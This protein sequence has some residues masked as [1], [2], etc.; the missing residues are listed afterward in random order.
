[1]PPV[2]DTALDSRSGSEKTLATFIFSKSEAPLRLDE[3]VKFPIMLVF[4]AMHLFVAASA[5]LI[6]QPR[7]V[8]GLGGRMHHTPHGPEA[9]VW[10]EANEQD[11]I[12]MEVAENGLAGRSDDAPICVKVDKTFETSESY[13]FYWFDVVVPKDSAFTCSA[14]SLDEGYLALNMYTESWYDGG[15]YCYVSSESKKVE[16]TL[17]LPTETIGIYVEYFGTSSTTINVSC[18]NEPCTEAVCGDAFCSAGFE[19][20]VTP[21]PKTDA[22]CKD[23]CGYTC[24]DGTCDPEVGENE[25]TCVRDC[26]VCAEVEETV[27]LEEGQTKEY[28]IEL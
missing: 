28:E 12:S 1:M 14:S 6:F 15:R 27:F 2:K 3:K 26:Y 21:G 9:T 5:L 22:T 25:S 18:N 4:K 10:V 17:G 13:F 23:D 24:G 8:A 7:T 20:P 11:A 16:C 19:T